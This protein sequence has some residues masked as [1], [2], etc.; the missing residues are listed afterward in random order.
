MKILLIISFL[1]PLVYIGYLVS[2]LDKFLSGNTNTAAN[3]INAS[4]AVVL[5]STDIAIKTVELLEDMEVQVVH[6]LDPFQLIKEQE[7]CFLF[8]LSDSDADNIAFCKLGKKLYC[9]ES[10]ISI[11]N[12]KR[13]ENMF[14]SE[15]IRYLLDGRISAAKLIKLVLQQSEVYLE[16]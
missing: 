14:I 11:C 12:D 1:I 3:T 10:M 7:L 16:H 13:N 9:I 8:A 6:L 15:N 2:Q 5:G 4:S